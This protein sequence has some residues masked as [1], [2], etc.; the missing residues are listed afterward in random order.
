MPLAPAS[1]VIGE[2]LERYGHLPPGAKFP[3]SRAP[4]NEDE[5]RSLRVLAGINHLGLGPLYEVL[6]DHSGPAVR[7]ALL[8]LLSALQ[9]G[10]GVALFCHLGKN[11]TGLMSALV[12]G[13]LGAPDAAILDDYAASAGQVDPAAQALALENMRLPPDA[14]TTAFDGAHPEDMAWVLGFLRAA[15]QGIDGYL[16]AVGFGEELRRQLRAELLA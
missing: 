7:E 15:Y 10:E 4:L 13:I 16:D 12:L 6:L 8:A 11:R 9:R 2:F 5:E 1:L 3:V 14:V